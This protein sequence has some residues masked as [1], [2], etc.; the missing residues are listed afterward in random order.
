MVD[1]DGSEY[2]TPTSGPTSCHCTHTFV[3]QW[4]FLQNYCKTLSIFIEKK[5]VYLKPFKLL[6]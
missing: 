4:H 5:S 2:L 3:I 6:L 1:M